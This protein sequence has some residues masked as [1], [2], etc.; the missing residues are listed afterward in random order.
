MS[1]SRRTFI[2]TLVP[3][4]TLAAGPLNAAAILT[5]SKG[6]E[7]G[8]VSIKTSDGRIPAYRAYPN[9]RKH[10]P[11]ILVVQEIFGV[12]E[13]IK[14]VCRRLAKLG[15][16][17]V[18]PALYARYGDPA[19]YDAAHIEQLIADL[20]SKVPDAEVMADLDAA[21]DFAKSEGADAARLGIT[22][23]CWGGRIV[24]LYAAHTPHLKAGVACYGPLRGKS[25]ALHPKT[26]IDLAPL[27]RAPILGNYA[28]KD[29][30]IPLVDVVEMRAALKAG[31]N[32]ASKITLYEN[33]QH[34]FFA[35]Y[36][37]S[38]NAADAKPAW[39]EAVN[40]LSANGLK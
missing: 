28:G 6:L 37:A 12:H 17:A 19:K 3:G 7:A 8:E 15:Y 32:T 27:I 34:G 5:D 36:R 21:A 18:A 20:V 38:Y 13:F 14:D 40:W 4:F 24:W 9:T 25:D 26:A 11:V 16:Y 23:F 22:G 35:D 2:T 33:S 39:A 30:G 10:A 31:G 29:L 1:Q